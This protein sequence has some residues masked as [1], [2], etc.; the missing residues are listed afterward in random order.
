[1]NSREILLISLSWYHQQSQHPFFFEHFHA[2]FSLLVHAVGNG[3]SSTEI[4]LTHNSCE[5]CECHIGARKW[6]EELNLMAQ[7]SFS[8]CS[9]VCLLM[10]INPDAFINV[11]KLTQHLDKWMKTVEL[12]AYNFRIKD[13]QNTFSLFSFFLMATVPLIFQNDSGGLISTMEQKKSE[14]FCDFLSHLLGPLEL[15]EVASWK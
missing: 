14:L 8:L 11:I 2:L 15:N 5:Q 1:M 4:M 12:G 3:K 7:I 9:R 10:I 13:H 6:S